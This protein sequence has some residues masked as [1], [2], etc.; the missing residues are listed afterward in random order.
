M[1]ALVV[2]AHPD[3]E[4]MLCGGTLALLAKE[5]WKVHYLCATHG[6]GG[7][8]GDPPVCTV[9]E[10]GNVREGELVCAVGSLGG[11]SLTF[12]GYVDPQVGPDDRL[13]PFEADLDTFAGQIADSILQH[14]AALVITHGS[15]GEYGHPAHLLT[16]Q[17]AVAAVTGL[18][19]GAP[20]LYTMQAAYPEHPHP[21]LANKDDPAHLVLDVSSVKV[22]KTNAA[23]CHRTQHAMFIRNVSKDLGYPVSL[24][25]VVILEESLHRNY[26]PV[27]EDEIATDVFMQT[28]DKFRKE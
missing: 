26:P 21:R 2:F 13:F 25:E 23:L 28:L 9:D 10:L 22:R 24:E 4:T 5:G 3:D 12:L 15:N 14:K 17:A 18:S 8:V 27:P 1:N 6:Q 11:S 20:L 19:K 7:E 16:H